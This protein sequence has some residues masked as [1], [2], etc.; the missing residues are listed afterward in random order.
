MSVFVCVC[1]LR[2]ICSIVVPLIP[3]QIAQNQSKIAPDH[4]SYRF[5]SL[6]K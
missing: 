4:E 2:S 1:V 3:A 5:G 6:S